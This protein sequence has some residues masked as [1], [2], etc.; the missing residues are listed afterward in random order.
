[1]RRRKAILAVFILTVLVVS[2]GLFAQDKPSTKPNCFEQAAVRIRPNQSIKLFLRDKSKIK[3]KFLGVDSVQSLLTMISINGADTNRFAYPIL[4]VSKIE[5]K[6]GRGKS[7]IYGLIFGTIG[8]LV[9]GLIDGVVY[10]DHDSKD[11]AI[12]VGASAGA[13]A[14]Y[15]LSFRYTGFIKCK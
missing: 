4:D 12:W 5:Y 11:F 9:S 3:G 13:Y 2:Q 7:V 10:P 14:L 6:I 1:M 8:G 15:G